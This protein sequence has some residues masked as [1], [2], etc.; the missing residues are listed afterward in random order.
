MGCL[1]SFSML[2]LEA[3]RFYISMISSLCFYFVTC[4]FGVTYKQSFN[5]RSQK[6][7]PMWSSKRFLVLALAFMPLIHFELIFV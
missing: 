4:T 6:F 3:Q 2:C 1:L 7:P 5:P